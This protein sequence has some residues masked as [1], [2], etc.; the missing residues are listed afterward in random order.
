MESR[1]SS[2]LSAFVALR[3]VGASIR[4]SYTGTVEG[5]SG[6]LCGSHVYDKRIVENSEKATEEGFFVTRARPHEGVRLVY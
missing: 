4:I 3:L 2:M 6:M 1:I 5:E